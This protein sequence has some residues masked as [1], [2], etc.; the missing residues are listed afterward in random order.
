MN[1]YPSPPEKNW[2]FWSNLYKYLSHG[3]TRV[4]KFGYMTTSTIQFEPRDKTLVVM[5]WTEVM[6]S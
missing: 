1:Q 3:N 6:E 2:F 5:P 4:I